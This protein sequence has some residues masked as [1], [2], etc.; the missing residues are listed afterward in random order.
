MA[1]SN[2]S[3]IY[4]TM[5][6]QGRQRFGEGHPFVVAGSSMIRQP[7]I[8]A[9]DSYYFGDIYEP[10]KIRSAFSG[11]GKMPGS[12]TAYLDHLDYLTDNGWPQL[13][14]LADF[15]RVTASPP[16]WKF[17][18]HEDMQERASRAK[19]VLL[20][21]HPDRVQK[22]NINS[23]QQLQDALDQM[24]GV[25][26]AHDFPPHLFVVEDLSRDVIECL[27]M[28]L[29]VDPMLFR[30]HISDYVWYNIRDPWIELPDLEVIYRQRSCFSIRY[31]QTRYFR[32]GE[33]LR[34][35]RDETSRF[36]IL[37]RVDGNGNWETGLDLP[38]SNIGTIRSKMSFW[39]QPRNSKIPKSVVAILLVDPSV[40][41]GHPIWG[42]YNNLVPC[43][44]VHQDRCD[45]R[46][47]GSMLDETIYWLEKMSA[48]EI[49]LIPQDPR[50]LCR[51]PLGIV[52][53]EWTMLLRYANTR[54]S[55][56]EWEVEDP[57]LRHKG[58]GLALTLENLHTWRRRFPIYKNIISE[59]MERVI[60]RES[61]LYSTRDSLRVL[62]KDFEI[63]LSN[64]DDL[65]HRA[66]RMM[67]VVTA[68]LSIEES[69]KALQQNR[70][71]GRLT[72]L[73]AL[74][75]PLSF[76]S[77]FFSMNEDITRLGKTFWIYLAV[78]LPVTVTALFVT[79]YSHYLA[80]TLQRLI[81]RLEEKLHTSHSGDRNR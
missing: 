31:A 66:E 8:H 52:C 32:D 7:I 17:L 46:S 3:D 40:T 60:R 38:S 18:S 6:Y 35:A 11:S 71:L 62:E 29:D 5:R 57:D 9:G 50:I 43:P 23:I 48:D 47:R 65:H 56:L 13:R 14:Y 64:L 49:R 20:V 15:M 27:G 44:S 68:V 70:S 58:E 55:Q 37:R 12:S 45:R 34:N 33:S 54:F 39:V 22:L 28:H 72:Y 77:S 69:Q 25:N 30:G 74:F 61:F 42:G 53:S 79:R 76:I 16:K 59:G 2:I 24:P 73:A 36:N 75:V 21:F 19:A 63:L 26:D 80:K 51:K 41:E 10:S 81:R 67:S 1:G 78:A 4:S